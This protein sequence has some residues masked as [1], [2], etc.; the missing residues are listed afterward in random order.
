MDAQ[1]APA[2]TAVICSYDRPAQLTRAVES[3]LANDYPRFELT[4]V[5]QSP[6]GEIAAAL[7]PYLEDPRFRHLR[8]PPGLNGARNAAIRQAES[9]LIALTDDDCEV[10]PDWLKRVAAAFTEDERI[11]VVFGSTI[12]APHDG[13]AG[14]V[15]AY[16]SWRPRLAFEVRQLGRVG[17]M[18]ACLALRRSVWEAIGGLDEMLGKGGRFLAGDEGDIA[19]QA[20]RAGYIV[21]ETPAVS[22]VHH[23]FRASADAREL[24]HAYWHGTGA[25][26][27][28]HLKRG[29]VSL[30]PVLARL[31]G[32]WLRGASPIATSFGGRATALLRLR[33]FLSG[34]IAGLAWPVDRD[35]RHF[36]PGKGEPHREAAG[37][38]RHSHA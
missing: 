25:V 23:G 34:L 8:A 11:G 4:V 6:N 20:L 14:F 13:A 1:T 31:A 27:G 26:F 35:T 33:S 15:P 10:G 2:I 37:L 29:Q 12:P 17:G 24:A 9:E 5:D 19:L 32:R 38:G 3:V 30:V 28:K 16:I 22:V 36:R 7:N 21:Y 18:G